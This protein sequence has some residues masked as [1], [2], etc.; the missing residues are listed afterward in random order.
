MFERAAAAHLSE[1]AVDHRVP[2]VQ[3]H[4]KFLVNWRAPATKEVKYSKESVLNVPM[5][6]TS[7]GGEHL[8]GIIACDSLT[9][10]SVG[11]SQTCVSGGVW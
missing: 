7:L 5:Q 1:S 8:R 9:S 3:L 10:Q 4:C 2:E 11:F 6:R